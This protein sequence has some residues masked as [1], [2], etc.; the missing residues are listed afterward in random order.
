MA[1]YVECKVGTSKR[2]KKRVLQYLNNR[3]GVK[4]DL[5]VGKRGGLSYKSPGSKNRRYVRGICE[6]TTCSET[7]WKEA[8]RMHT[9]KYTKKN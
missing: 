6:N 3:T 4:R 7:F 8:K 1:R 5:L 2:T 9:K